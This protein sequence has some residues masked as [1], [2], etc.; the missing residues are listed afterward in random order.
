MAG[1]TGLSEG[2]SISGSNCGAVR[3]GVN[4]GDVESELGDG[5][6]IGI[7]VGDGVGV[8]LTDKGDVLLS[9]V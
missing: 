8:G 2:S 3:V 9:R 1:P 6:G 5:V 7:G 4:A